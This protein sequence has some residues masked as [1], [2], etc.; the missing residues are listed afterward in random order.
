MD[1]ELSGQ[2][3]DALSDNR[4]PRY[5]KQLIQDIYAQLCF[6]S[7]NHSAHNPEYAEDERWVEV[8]S[9]GFFGGLN[10][11]SLTKRPGSSLL[12]KPGRPNLST[13]PSIPLRRRAFDFRGQ[14]PA[15]QMVAGPAMAGPA[16][17]GPMTGG[18][19]PM[20]GG[21][22]PM[23]G[24]PGPVTGGPMAAGG[25]MTGG[26]GSMTESGRG[27]GVRTQPELRSGCAETRAMSPPRIDV[28]AITRQLHGDPAQFSDSRT[29]ASDRPGEG[30]PGFK[31]ASVSRSA[32]LLHS[33]ATSAT[34]TA[35][36]SPHQM[37]PAQLM[38]QHSQGMAQQA[39]AQQAMM[40]QQ[41]I[42]R[43]SGLM[44]SRSMSRDR[45]MQGPVQ[46][47]MQGQAMQGQ[48]MQGQAMQGQA[49]QGQAMQG[50]AMQGQACK[51]KRCRDRRCRGRR[52]KDKRCKDK[53]CKDR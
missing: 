17:N 9:Y 47:M 32:H 10:P 21:P 30:R 51:D 39:M 44:V 6:R 22:G 4:V 34:G 28:G 3:E 12:E 40:Q 11:G 36:G 24:G 23:A 27:E 29:L 19:G 31:S 18:P 14:P 52:C 33:A 48:A 5:V 42:N 49:M 8:G 26:P 20:T 13:L 45:Q 38:A 41:T 46:G 16:M 15:S 25:P 35:P 50:Q 7:V 1:D 37:H 2:V 43:A 53:R